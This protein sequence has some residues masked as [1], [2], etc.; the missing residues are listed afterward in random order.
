MTA[1]AIYEVSPGTLTC[2]LPRPD[3]QSMRRLAYGVLA[4]AAALALLGVVLYVAG[5]RQTVAILARLSGPELL[6]LVAAA[7]GVTLFSAL[8]WQTILERDGH[9]LP[10]WL[11]FRLT[12]LAFAVGWAIPSG[13]VAGIVAAAYYLRRRGVPLARGLASFVTGRFFEI[14]GCA[15]I[16]PA[17]LLSSLGS[18]AIVRGLAVGTVS[19]VGFVYLDLILR[20]RLVRRSLVRLRPLLPGFSRP[21]LD[22][23]LEFCR[24]VADFFRAP[25][26]RIL[27]V[28]GYAVLAVSVAFLRALLTARFLGL[29]LTMPELVVMFIVTAFLISVPFLPGAVGIYEGG[30]AGAFEVLG[31]SRADG[32]AYAMT[33]HAA[34]L[35]V[36]AVGFLFLAHLGLSLA[37]PRKAAGEGAHGPRVRRVHRPA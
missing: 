8:A 10:L 11:L 37:A 27:L 29:H 30:I 4:V 22:A 23:A 6:A 33:I 18:H 21:S 19:A 1:G 3:G 15:L 9:A 36:V 31:H 5:A 17:I 35:V 26:P 32:V 12:V 16:F 7:F 2:W 34:E 13:F 14:T 28:A 25:L 24:A 20:W